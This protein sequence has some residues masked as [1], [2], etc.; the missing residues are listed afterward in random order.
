MLIGLFLKG[1]GP[2]FVLGTCAGF[3]PVQVPFFVFPAHDMPQVQ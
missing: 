1:S 3:V 2:F